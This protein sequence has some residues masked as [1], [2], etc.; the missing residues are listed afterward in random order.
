MIDTEVTIVKKGDRQ[1]VRTFLEFTKSVF[2]WTDFSSWYESGFWPDEYI[3]HSIIVDGKIVS[4]VSITKM[5][6]LIND[7]PVRGIQIGTVGT[8]P[9]FRGRGLSGSLMR[10]VLE[11]YKDRT[12]LFFLFANES[13]LEFYPKYGFSRKHETLYYSAVKKREDR[14]PLKKLDWRQSGDLDLIQELLRK[15]LPLTSLFGAGNYHPITL[16]HIINAYPD[17]I[18][19][20]KDQNMIRIGFLKGDTFHL[21]DL[22]FTGYPDMEKT[23]SILPSSGVAS[24]ICYHFPP[25]RT[26]FRV[27]DTGTDTESILFV[28][29]DFNP[30]EG[31]KFPVT[32]GT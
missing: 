18:H 12:D 20:D 1:L 9:E 30:P 25:D 28:K 22:I 16:W 13:V 5:D 7:H 4:N 21:I 2:S 10:Y 23:L 27:D 29:G 6:V 17:K 24:R 26:G 14:Q 15:R 3:P 11:K 31:Y 8:I 19:Y 32:A